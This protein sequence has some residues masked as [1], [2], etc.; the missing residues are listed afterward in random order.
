MQK[1]IY[2]KWILTKFRMSEQIQ[3]KSSIQI[4]T[5]PWM[6]EWPMMGWL[7]SVS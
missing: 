4:H 2:E 7:S 3:G 1:K 5:M 6:I